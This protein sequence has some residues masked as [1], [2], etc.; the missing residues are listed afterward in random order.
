[1]TIEIMEQAPLHSVQGYIARQ[2]IHLD[3]LHRCLS[4]LNNERI[5]LVIRA[6]PLYLGTGTPNPWRIDIRPMLQSITSEVLSESAGLFLQTQIPLHSARHS[7]TIGK[8]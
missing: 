7:T 2:R 3:D 1:M 8:Q 6:G 4:A 5:V